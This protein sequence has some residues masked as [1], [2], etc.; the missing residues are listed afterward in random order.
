MF[1]LK[2]VL[3]KLIFL[4]CI[5]VTYFMIFLFCKKLD[6][7]FY[8]KVKKKKF[9]IR[10]YNLKFNFLLYPKKKIVLHFS[11]FALFWK[12]GFSQFS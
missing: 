2:R 9:I 5:K 11:A 12:K 7:I 4:F 10:F 8:D 6:V 1:Q 3:S